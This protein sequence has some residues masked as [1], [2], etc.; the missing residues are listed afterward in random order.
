MNEHNQK[1]LTLSN[2]TYIEQELVQD[3]SFKSIG[4]VLH[5]DPTTISKEVRRYRKQVRGKS[6]SGNCNS[7][8]YWDN[9]QVRGDDFEVSSCP[10]SSYC[11]NL[12]KR[13]WREHT[14]HYCRTYIPF[15]CDKPSHFPY[16]CNACTY[17]ADCRINHYIY[18]ASFAQKQYEK[19]LVKCR[20]G[21]NLT[22]EE[23][24]SLNELISPLVLKGQPLSHIFAVHSDE[25][26]VC[27]RTLYNY[28]DQNVFKARNIDLPRR[29]RYKRRK[30]RSEP[31]KKNIQQIYRNKRTYT[32]FE[33]FIE[34][35]PD[36]DVVE[37]DTVKG[38]RAAGKCLLTLLFRSC[39]FMLVILLPN[40]TQKSVVN[41]I[42]TL[43]DTFGI[44]IFKKY[45][46]VILTDNGSEF[47]NPWDIEK[48]ES[49][50]HR[51]YV[52][53]CDPYVSNQ[54][55][56]LEKNHEYIRYV[57][58]KGRSMYKYTQDDIS[59]MTSHINSTARD[60]LNGATPFN[61]AE[62]LLDKKIPLLAGLKKVSPDEVMLKPALIETSNNS[63][64]DAHE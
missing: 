54:K 62:L 17:E 3:S 33:R 11:H 21:I 14:Q 30:K 60:S 44:R 34:A 39:N 27:R 43:S 13:C 35:H 56:R 41:A 29:V 49:G 45:F 31:R 37:M 15:N 48:T 25:I 36:I 12:C 38:G 55:G 40:C 32:D 57:I 59:L 28:F 2:R 51:T 8:K 64:E 9:C 6:V 23:L 52:F 22:P 24:D 10:R 47:K 53:Y 46:P 26:P 5:K 4:N 42:N 1:H 18:Q 50:T 7:C 61:L 19:N 20:E 16:I 63:K 58:P